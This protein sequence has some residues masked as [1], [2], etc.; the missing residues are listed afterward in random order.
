M[1]DFLR[2]FAVSGLL[3]LAGGCCG[4]TPPHIA[5]IARAVSGVKP[6]EP[7]PIYKNM[8]LSGL[9]ALIVRD[10]QNFMNVGERCNIA[11]SRKFKKMVGVLLCLLACVVLCC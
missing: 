8:R 4:T 2:D 10:N 3:N 11:G 6:R 1:Y 9:E 7:Q 5:E